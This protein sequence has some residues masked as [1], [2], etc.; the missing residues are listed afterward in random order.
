MEHI[1]LECLGAFGDP[2]FNRTNKCRPS[3]TIRVRNRT[4][5]PTHKSLKGARHP[6][7]VSFS[8]KN[9]IF[10]L[11]FG[12][13]WRQPK[14]H[15]DVK[16]PLHPPSFYIIPLNGVSKNWIPRTRLAAQNLSPLNLQRDEIP[17]PYPQPPSPCFIIIRNTNYLSSKIDII[18]HRLSNTEFLFSI[19]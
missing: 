15:I 10:Q 19:G 14:Y 5:D 4:K 13:L 18:T 9:H 16:N 2:C 6:K 1:L 17:V 12:I 8:P 11:H 3:R 7:S